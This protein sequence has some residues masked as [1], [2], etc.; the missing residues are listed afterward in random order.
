MGVIDKKEN[1][2]LCLCR[3][4]NSDVVTIATESCAMLNLH[5]HG[6]TYT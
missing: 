2:T 3:V 4:I 5:M 6:S 1:R